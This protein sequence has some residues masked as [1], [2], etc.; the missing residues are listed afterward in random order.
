MQVEVR[1]SNIHDMFGHRFALQIEILL[2]CILLRTSAYDVYVHT[3]Y[4][5]M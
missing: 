2:A 1:T 4:L 5:R 3:A